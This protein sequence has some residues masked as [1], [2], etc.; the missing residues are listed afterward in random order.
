MSPCPPPLA[1]VARSFSWLTTTPT[2]SKYEIALSGAGFLAV[3][4]R[5]AMSVGM[6]VD[7]VHPDVVVTDLQLHGATGRNVMQSLKKHGGAK[8]IPVVLLT[9]YSSAEID[10]QAQNLGCA[11]V[12]TKPC[13]PDE[14]GVVLRRVLGTPA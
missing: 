5:D 3:G 10:Q 7:A 1:P 2:H 4:T 12:L 13:T 9:G 11:A 14:L 6:Q 8:A